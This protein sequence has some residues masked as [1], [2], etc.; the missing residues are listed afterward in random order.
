MRGMG[1]GE[2]WLE[3]GIAVEAA[4][5]IK[6]FDNHQFKVWGQ[7]ADWAMGNARSRIY[8]AKDHSRGFADDD[9]LR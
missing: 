9:Q 6:V 4:D 3:S 2:T 8:V 7:L 1:L 5:A